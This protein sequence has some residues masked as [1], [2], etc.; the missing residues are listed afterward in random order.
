MN[1]GLFVF[2]GWSIGIYL[3][4]IW[5]G[6]RT[7][8]PNNNY[9]GYKKLSE[10][11]KEIIE[12][13]DNLIEKQAKLIKAYQSESYEQFKARQEIARVIEKA[14]KHFD[15][16]EA[17]AIQQLKVLIDNDTV[18]YDSWKELNK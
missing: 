16:N 7:Y 4:G 17:E 9:F 1:V 13:Q 3:V 8:G 2:C 5:W 18:N 15:I 6:S 11:R 10:I 14:S 12:K